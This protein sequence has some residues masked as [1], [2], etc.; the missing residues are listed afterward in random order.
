MLEHLVTAKTLTA[1]GSDPRWHCFRLCRQAAGLSSGK[2][3]RTKLHWYSGRRCRQWIAASL[4]GSG[5][6]QV[7]LQAHA[8][9]SPAWFAQRTVH[10]SF[11]D[12]IASLTSACR[13]DCWLKQRTWL[14]WEEFCVSALFTQAFFWIWRSRLLPRH[15]ESLIVFRREPQPPVRFLCDRLLRPLITHRR[16][17]CLRDRRHRHVFFRCRVF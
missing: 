17:A 8:G 11:A 9:S 6:R 13:F 16:Q 15:L 3:A 4:I 12:A 7:L 2:S 1:Q 5:Q 10:C 14:V